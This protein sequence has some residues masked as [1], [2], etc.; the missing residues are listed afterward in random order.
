[1][2]QDI[3]SNSKAGSE[4]SDWLSLQDGIDKILDKQKNKCTLPLCQINQ[5]QFLQQFTTLCI[6][7]M[8]RISASIHIAK[9]HNDGDGVYFASHIQTLAQHYQKFEQLPIEQLRWSAQGLFVTNNKDMQRV[10]LTWVQSQKAGL[11]TSAHFCRVLNS[12][13]LPD[14]GIALRN[15]LSN[16][17][18]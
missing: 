14:L 10:A 7:G 6:K 11:V 15:P 8:K 9:W 17:T 13:I 4:V 1:L 2:F 16:H 3:S 5:Y 12:T 18:A